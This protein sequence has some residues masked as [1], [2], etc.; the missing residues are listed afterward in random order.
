M[1]EPT[2]I[3]TDNPFVD[4]IIY[5][6][7]YMAMNAVVKDEITANNNETIQSMRSHE[8]YVASRE[9]RQKYYMWKS[10]PFEVYRTVLDSSYSDSFITEGLLSNP[11]NLPTEFQQKVANE[12]AKLTLKTY[13]ETNPYYRSLIGLVPIQEPENLPETEYDLRFRYLIPLDKYGFVND[14]IL[15]NGVNYTYL[16]Q[17]PLSMLYKIESD[18][19]LDK[20]LEDH[21]GE[22]WIETIR[23]R[24]ECDDILGYLIECRKALNFELLDLPGSVDEGLKNQFTLKYNQNRMYVLHNIYSEAF[25]IGSDCYDNFIQV[26]IIIITV[27]DMIDSINDNVSR[28]DIVDSRCIEYIFEQ[29]GL[30]YFNEIPI[31]YKYAMVKN[32]NQLLKYK[33]SAKCMIDICSLFGFDSS[34]VFQLYMLRKRKIDDNGN[35]VLNYTTETV[36]INLDTVTQTASIITLSSNITTQIDLTYPVLDYFENGNKI[37]VWIDDEVIP[38]DF[39]TI[40]HQTL[41]IKYPEILQGKSQIQ[42]KYLYNEES[43]KFSKI[44]K[45]D[46]IHREEEIL[47]DHSVLEFELHPP[48]SN[49]FMLGGMVNIVYGSI[50]L[51][52][53]LYYINPETN[54][55]SFTQTFYDNYRDDIIDYIKILYIYSNT[56][57]INTSEV[58]V[59]C[60]QQ[61]QTTFIIPAP[62]KDYYLTESKFYVSVAGTY[63][64]SE[65]YHVIGNTLVFNDN[66]DGIAQGQYLT[67]H[68][69]YSDFTSVDVIENVVQMTVTDPYLVSFKIPLPYESYLTDQNIMFIRVNGVYLSNKNYDIIHNM[70]NLHTGTTV[71]KGDVIEFVF[72]YGGDNVLYKRDVVKATTQF[73]QS[74]EIPFPFNGFLARLNK[75]KVYYNGIEYEEETDYVII[76]NKLQILSIDKSIPKDDFLEFY[77]F[78]LESNVTNITMKENQTMVLLKDQRTFT[79]PVPFY[80]YFTTGNFMI[81]TVGSTFIRPDQYTVDNGTITFNDDTYVDL[82]VGRSINYTFIYH[83]I[84]EQFNKFIHLDSGYYEISDSETLSNGSLKLKVPWPFADYLSLGNELSLRINN[85]KILDETAYDIIDNDYVIIYNPKE[86]LYPYGNSIQFVFIYSCTGYETKIKEDLAKDIELKFV[87]VPI[88]QNA[89]RYLNNENYYLNYESVTGNDPTWTGDY[90][91]EYIKQIYLESEFSYVRTKYF[92][93]NAKSSMGDI[94]YQLPYFMNMILDHIKTEDDLTLKLPFISTTHIFKFNDVLVY[95]M[96]LS[97]RF[98]GIDDDIPNI[99]RAL[100]IKGF[101]F[102]ADLAKIASDISNKLTKEKITVNI[103]ETWKKFKVYNGSA[104][105]SY[106]ELIN[107]YTTNTEVYDLVVYQMLN[108]ENKIMFDIYKKIYESLMITKESKEYFTF[109]DGS[110]APTLTDWL[111]YRDIFLYQSLMSIDGTKDSYIRDKNISQYLEECTYQLSQYIEGDQFRYVFTQF[112]GSNNDTLLKYLSTV[113]NFF[114]SYK[115]QLYDINVEYIF[116]DKLENTLRP[117]DYLTYKINLA[118]SEDGYNIF[119]T[120]NKMI[121]IMTIADKDNLLSFTDKLIVYKRLLKSILIDDDDPIIPYDEATITHIE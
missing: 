5:W 68:F 104:I 27:A 117:I 32:I 37:E 55:L 40:D 64:S 36:P 30:P 86:T 63:I 65:R 50:M 98:A 49:Y 67:F 2:M 83:S 112:S 77:F 75:M 113:I 85:I 61:H 45:Y 97:H 44:P 11:E 72:V 8:L 25:K 120:I 66:D 118:L 39:Y 119:E 52:K 20:I 58:S 91:S 46:I 78:Y 89:D 38:E 102:E 105:P 96:A 12:M 1:Y 69:I 28:R 19:I 35:Y 70:V 80:N 47:Y 51:D 31:K 100:Y 109:D 34:Q 22:M 56:I 116:D 9:N 71:F 17:L 7:K 43:D 21:P 59:L 84:Y 103:D 33:S 94:A 3:Y 6:T 60:E 101:N 92:S 73:Q 26:L 54:M 115:S 95:M 42:I 90:S 4:Y 107:I 14:L 15:Q 16:H 29:Y 79:I 53:T 74:F 48:I 99:Q 114:K 111:K 87:K 106:K 41:T 81:V 88:L 13:E 110:L 121:G 23:K 82:S 57:N 18:G 10:Y 24:L 93:L 76:D 62:F 108:A